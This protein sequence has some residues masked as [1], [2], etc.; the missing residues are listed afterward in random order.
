MI[1]TDVAIETGN[2]SQAQQA[3]DCNPPL[4]CAKRLSSIDSVSI[5]LIF[6]SLHE[7]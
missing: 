6:H 5:Q 4:H 2:R 1:R 3:E 7:T